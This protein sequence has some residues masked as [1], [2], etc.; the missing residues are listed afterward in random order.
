MRKK[1]Q[2]S[3]GSAAVLIAIIALIIV[4]YIALLPSEER[5]QLLYGENITEEKE[6]K[7]AGEEML[8]LAHPGR[9]DYLEEDKIE[10]SIPN[11]HLYTET[12]GVMFKK[13]D[14]IHISK[15]LLGGKSKEV[16]FTIGNLEN[17]KDVIMGYSIKE[18][19]GRLII[20]LNGKEIFN[21]EIRTA[22]PL[23]LPKEYLK[24]GGN[25]LKFSVSR[26]GILGSNSYTLENIR[27]TGD[28]TDVSGQTASAVF[29]VSATEKN[30][31]D[32]VRLKF[33]PHCNLSLI[34]KLDIAINEN[35]VFSG[36]PDYCG[37]SLPAIEFSPSNIYSDENT[38]SF[39]TTEGNYVLDQIKVQSYLK[40]YTNPTYYFNLDNDLYGDIQDDDKDINLIMKFADNIA[41]KNL[42]IIINSKTFYLDGK[43]QEY[44]W[45]LSDYVIKGNNAVK[46]EPLTTID[47]V[48]LT[49]ELD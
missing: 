9:L 46:I 26:S 1:A 14:S 44:K 43:D 13:L 6:G 33:V 39:S 32:Y 12:E 11:L 10:H 21:K 7:A 37:Y 35:N 5:H 8:L 45:D 47:I 42:R 22:Q 17:T 49:V 27:V 25:V 38:I 19:E 40:E 20:S 29:I 2:V 4:L 30:H 3:G 36:K 16:N 24:E 15:W 18:G 34:G 41:R 31:L 48:D 28:V 23:D